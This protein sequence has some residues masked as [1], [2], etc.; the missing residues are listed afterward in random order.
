MA[1][2]TAAPQP[3]H[4]VVHGVGTLR[5][6]RAHWA[7]A[8]LGLDYRTEAVQSRTGQTKTDAYTRLDPRQKI[9]VLVDGSFVLTE[10]A[11]IVTYLGETYGRVGPTLVPA[12][13]HERARYNEWIS[14]ICMELDATS[15]YVLRRHEGLPEIYGESP[16]ASQVARDY[17]AKMIDAAAVRYGGDRDYL[18]ESGFSGA[19]IVMA[20]CLIWA[21]RLDIAV[22]PALRT[23]FERVTSRPAFTAALAANDP[24]RAA[25]NLGAP[26]VTI[27]TEAD[28]T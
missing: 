6:L 2:D 9:P 8:E 23:Y 12:E 10:S 3:G 18:L 4:L 7:M 19:D 26:D 5:A 24:S 16:V 25:D 14:F 17:F 1:P 21:D 27:A 28:A 15:L 11:V 20:T 13:P 22:P